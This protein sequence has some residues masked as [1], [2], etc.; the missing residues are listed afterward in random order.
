MVFDGTRS[1]Y[2]ED[3]QVAPIVEYGRTKAAAEL[4]IG[5]ATLKRKLKAY[6]AAR[7]AAP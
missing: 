6:G 4:Q 2:R 7:S 1:W 3:D 5:L